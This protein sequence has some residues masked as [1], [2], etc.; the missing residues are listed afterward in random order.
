M[1]KNAVLFRHQRG[2]SLVELMIAMVV[3][4]IL[5]N[6]IFNI[7]LSSKRAYRTTEELGRIQENARYALQ[8][9]TKDLRMTGYMGCF[10]E[11]NKTDNVKDSKKPI[12]AGVAY[13]DNPITG[14]DAQSNTGTATSDW[15][16]NL[17]SYFSTYSYFSSI[18]PIAGSDII[19]IQRAVPFSTSDTGS[20]ATLSG[21]IQIDSNP[22]APD[23]IA[24]GDTLVISDCKDSDIFMV[25]NDIDGSS[26]PV[27]I[28]HDNSVNTS[29][30]LSKS[31]L[32]NAKL[33]RMVMNGYYVGT[34]TDGNR[35]LYRTR[36]AGNGAMKKEEL[37]EGVE[38]MQ[39]AYGE[40]TNG[41]GVP[42]RY[43]SAGDVTDMG[44]IVTVRVGLLMYSIRE[45]SE[46]NDTRS[47]NVAG[48][49]VDDTG[50]IPTHGVDKSL[51]QVYTATVK[52]R[53]RGMQ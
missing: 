21:S 40:D 47:F 50:T 53:N 19:V 49:D 31:Y 37:L 20:L 8:T 5:M 38:T 4:L 28:S 32:P 11:V 12:A 14:Y 13:F 46:E 16:P 10:G 22:P 24:K 36:L 42:N 25:D 43:L 15:S 27:N 2:I 45:V 7:F 34:N 1:N 17:P 39:V 3:G 9:L 6:G 52:I 18:P 33:M 35:A 41:D 23:S 51:R 44:N 48:T 26:V 29:N 30:S